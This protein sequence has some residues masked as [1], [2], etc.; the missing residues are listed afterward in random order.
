MGEFKNILCNYGWKLSR[1]KCLV[2]QKE[3]L[4]ISAKVREN[5]YKNKQSE[6]WQTELAWLKF[7][8]GV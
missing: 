6:N 3:R 1:K 7:R 2:I 4:N 5:I 8:P